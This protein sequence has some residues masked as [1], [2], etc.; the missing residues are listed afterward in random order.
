MI[1]IDRD[2]MKTDLLPGRKLQRAVGKNSCSDSDAMTVGYASYSEESGVM[3]PHHH[4]EETV[5]IIDSKDGYVCWG[6]DQAHLPQRVKLC[7]GMI[8]H[9]P[10]NE[11]HVFTYDDGGFVDII[12][13]YGTSGNIRPEDQ[14]K[15]QPAAR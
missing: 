14:G 8:L 11:W 12:F 10:E 3:E 7:K 9:I 2:T 13:I 1:I 5:V 4:A 15:A 6:P